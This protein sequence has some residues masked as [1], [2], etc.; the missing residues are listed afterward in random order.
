MRYLIPLSL[1]QRYYIVICSDFSNG[2]W[3]ITRDEL[4]ASDA[5]RHSTAVLDAVA[6]AWVD[7]ATV[8]VQA[9]RVAAIARRGRPIVTVRTTIDH[10][11]TIHV[12]GINKIIWI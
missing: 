12:A 11:R 9:V 1:F 6:R 2:L 10:R 8:E 3:R 7:V 5:T 4:H